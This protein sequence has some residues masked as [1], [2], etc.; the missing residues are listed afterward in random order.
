MENQPFT[1]SYIVQ[2]SPRLIFDSINDIRAWWSADFSGDSRKVGDK[3]DVHFGNMHDST[4]QVVEMVPEKTIEWLVTDSRL[5]FLKINKQEWNGTRI[6]FDISVNEQ[7]TLI[8]FTHIG[9]TPEIE[10]YKDCFKGWSYYLDESL[11]PL[12]STGEG[13]PNSPVPVV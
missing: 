7:G 9:L 1:K 4:Q 8:H 11:I 13:Q 10:C 2:Q 5:S 6:R 3:F 12:I